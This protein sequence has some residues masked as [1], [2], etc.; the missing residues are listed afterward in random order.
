MGF[1]NWCFG[2][3]SA[4]WCGV[5]VAWL[6]L[7]W[8]WWFACFGWLC[9]SCGLGSGSLVWCVVGGCCGSLVTLRF[10]FGWVLRFEL[11]G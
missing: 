1:R 9:F 7:V 10:C 8:F 4:V 5:G 6:C 2:V 3:Y 11:V